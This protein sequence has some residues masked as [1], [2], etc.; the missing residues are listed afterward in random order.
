MKYD[1]WNKKNTYWF[2]KGKYQ[3]KSRSDSIL[4]SRVWKTGNLLLN[5]YIDLNK[6]YRDA[7]NNGGSNYWDREL[8]ESDFIGLEDNM[9]ELIEQIA[10]EY[11]S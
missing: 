3:K 4:Y 11:S 2:R 5:A 8:T 10:D 9:N 6:L 7:Y 1:R